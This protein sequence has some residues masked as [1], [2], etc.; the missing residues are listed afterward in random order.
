MEE[1][2]KSD[3]S[4]FP[5]EIIEDWILPS[6]KRH[7][8]PPSGGSWGVIFLDK[9]IHFWQQTSWKQIDI[10]L[11]E[12]LFSP[13][14]IRVIDGMVAAF[15]MG[16]ENT[17]KTVLGAEGKARYLNAL[18]H[19]LEHGIFPRPIALLKVGEV[20]SIADGHHRFVAWKMSYN[21]IEIFK[22]M[23][24]TSYQED[25]DS[26]RE[27]FSKKWNVSTI[28]PFSPIQKVW[29]AQESKT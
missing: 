4:N 8:W 18:K 3:L 9:D 10:D 27:K 21:L 6:A 28:A 19:I 14:T 22:K 29:I 15:G 7:G 11:T 25:I 24:G 26:L 5:N 20:Y 23:E 1:R 13:S 16:E 2:I 17:Y 12:A